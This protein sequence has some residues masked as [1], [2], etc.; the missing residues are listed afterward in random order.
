MLGSSIAHY[1]ITAKLGEGGMGEVYRATD[2]R[3]NRD[4]AIKLLPESFSSDADRLARFR[5]E[6]QVLASLNHANIGQIYGLEEQDGR[7]AIVLELIE[8]ET[9]EERIERGALPEEEALRTALQIAQA[10]EAAHEKGIVHRDLKPANVKVT[11]DGT[12]KVLDFGLAKILDPDGPQKEQDT[13]QSPTLTAQATQAGVILGTAAYMSPEQA[14]GQPVDKRSDIWSFAVVC[15]EMLTGRRVFDAPSVIETLA[16][17][18]TSTPDL[19]ELP[20]STPVPVRR[21]LR[22]CLAREPKSRLHDIADARIVLDD[23]VAGNVDPEEAATAPAFDPTRSTVRSWRVAVAVVVVGLAAGLLG[24]LLSNSREPA[25]R[26]PQHLAINLGA[27]RELVTGANSVVVFSPDGRSLVVLGRENGRRS[28]FRREL[29]Q[30]EGTPI[31]G[32]D[33]ADAP[34]F[35]PDGRWIGFA[36]GGQLMKVPVEGGRPIRLADARGAGGAT[37]LQDDTVVFAPMY[38]DGLF[39]VSAEG[40]TPERLTTPD[41]KDGELGH[42]WPQPLPGGRRVVFTA[43][44]TPVDRSR[45]GVV[46]LETREIRWVVDSG[47]YGRYLATGHLLYGRGQRL[48]ALP[49]DPATATAQGL[50]VPVVDEVFVSQTSGFAMAAVSTRGTLA[51]VTES[52]GNPPRELVWLDRSGRAV[53]AIEE[54][55][56][57]LSVSLSPDGRQAALTIRGESRDLWTYSFERGTLSRLTSME[58]TEFDPRWSHDGRE[59]FYVV[60]SPPFELHRIAVGAPDS[61]RRI[62]DERAERDTI[63]IAPSPDGRTIAFVVNESQTGLNLYARPID[64]SEPPHPIRTARSEDRHLSFSPDGHWVVY[65]SDETGRPE[66]YVQSFPGPG[67]RVQVSADGATEPVWAGNGEIFYRHHDEMRVVATRLGERFEFD[68]PRT[69]FSYPIVPAA[70]DDTR[71]FDVTPDGERIVAVTIPKAS[72]PRQVEIV[73]DW[74]VELERLVPSDWR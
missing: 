54:R 55:R 53:P 35:S 40:G 4:V 59:L 70:D 74:T 42:W 50:G 72:W 51:Y 12:V 47:F 38:S 64:G 7:S 61:G 58:T 62:W 13:A 28:L 23:V 63:D 48:Y 14:S 69:L 22:R 46:D 17:V 60:D 8:G 11:R 73:I 52:L 10:L 3:L 20:G 5:R 16:K 21:L 41:R 36:A 30:R 33:N 65:Q 29:G 6:A 56:R 45:I 19:G 39:R 68:A 32:T 9:I 26:E 49:F 43:F 1:R 25:T 44:R 57:Y 66:I 67:E 18:L 37:W 31:P 34:F 2:D 24:Y 15:C 71:T 27:S